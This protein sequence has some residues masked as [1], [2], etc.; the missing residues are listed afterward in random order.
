MSLDAAALRDFY[1]RPLGLTVRRII[2]SRVRRR[3][4]HT[5]GL[6]VAGYGYPAPY[7]GPF[8]ADAERVANLMPAS[9]GAIVW[10]RGGPSLSAL[11]EEGRLPIADNS[12]DRLLSVH[13]LE[14]CHREA[15]VLREFWRILK[16]E[17][18]L[19]LIVPNRSGMWARVDTTPFGAGK[20]FS[21]GQLQ[22]LLETA[23]LE[24]IEWSYALHLPP[25]EHRLVLKSA[26]ALE[27]MGHGIVPGIG[28]VIM[29]EAQKTM[30]AP[31]GKLS[32]VRAIGDV[33][34]VGGTGG[35]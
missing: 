26:I 30:E 21:R 20:P 5:R 16:P 7:L 23:L 10:P 3:W 27:R 24:P 4:R 8:R 31:V 6:V 25:I 13:A 18:R 12:V 9:Q 34:K 28:G 1:A 33:I 15:A 32:T 35:W 22:G 29:V 2:T 19:L 14:A 17:G 11:V